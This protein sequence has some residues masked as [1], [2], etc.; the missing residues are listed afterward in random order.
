MKNIILIAVIALVAYWFFILK[1]GTLELPA[2]PT[3]MNVDWT[4]MG[5]TPP[6]DFAGPLAPSSYMPSHAS[7]MS[8]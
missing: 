3:T 2:V 5:Q 7:L 8:I 1:K 4:P 6:I